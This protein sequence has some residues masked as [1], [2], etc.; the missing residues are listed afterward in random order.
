MHEKVGGGQI[1]LIWPH[2]IIIIIFNHHIAYTCSSTSSSDGPMPALVAPQRGCVGRHLENRNG[3]C[4]SGSY[5]CTLL[6]FFM[7]HHTLKIGLCIMHMAYSEPQTAKNAD[8]LAGYM[9]SA[10]VVVHTSL[11]PAGGSRI[12][13]RQFLSTVVLITIIPCESKNTCRRLVCF[14]C[15]TQKNDHMQFSVTASLH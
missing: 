9:R 6:F 1:T 8:R 14:H 5:S 12:L 13:I 2:I 10:G 7:L 4:V 15:S 3:M 11:R